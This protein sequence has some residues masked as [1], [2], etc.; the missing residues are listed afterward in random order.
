M[1]VSLSALNSAC[2]AARSAFVSFDVPPSLPPH[3]PAV[4]FA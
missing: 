2:A 1:K 4:T 3:A